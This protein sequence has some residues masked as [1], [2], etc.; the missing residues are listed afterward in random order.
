MA[1]SWFWWNAR[2]AAAAFRLLRI[3]NLT[4][5]GLDNYPQK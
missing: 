5:L 3:F 1:W 2:R 4:L